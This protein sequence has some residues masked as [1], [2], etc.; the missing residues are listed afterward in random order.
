MKTGTRSDGMIAIVSGGFAE[1]GWRVLSGIPERVSRLDF[2]LDFK[3]DPPDDHSLWDY[4]QDEGKRNGEG[5]SKGEVTF[6]RNLEGGQT[7]YLG[8]YAGLR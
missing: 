3:L 8:I 2:A 7:L 1:I 4:F 5:V 6:I